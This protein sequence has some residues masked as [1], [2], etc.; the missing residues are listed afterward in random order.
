MMSKSMVGAILLKSFFHY[1]WFEGKIIKIDP[2]A[3][4]DR[5]YLV[6]YKDGDNKDMPDDEIEKIIRREWNDWN[7]VRK[8]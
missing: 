2:N 4:S 1:G 8:V 6:K 7:W 5:I 3:K